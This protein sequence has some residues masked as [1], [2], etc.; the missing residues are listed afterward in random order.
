MHIRIASVVVDDQS[1]AHDFYTEKLGFVVKHDIPMGEHRW[2][3]VVA[4]DGGEMELGLEPNAHPAAKTFYDTLKA[5]GIPATMFFSDDIHTEVEQL[6]AKGV[7]F[8]KDP[9]EGGGVIMATFDDTCGNLIMLVQE[10]S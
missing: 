3:T 6:K 10:L 5:D 7:E 1:K 4:Q 9:V 2:L 8:T